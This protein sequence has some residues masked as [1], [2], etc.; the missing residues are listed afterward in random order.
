MH[1]TITAKR[2]PAVFYKNL[3]LSSTKALRSYSLFPLSRGPRKNRDCFS[4]RSTY[5][6]LSRMIRFTL[7]GEIYAVASFL[8]KTDD[9]QDNIG[10][11]YTCKNFFIRSRG[12]KKKTTRPLE[13][14]R[15]ILHN[16][17]LEYIQPRRRHSNW[18]RINLKIYLTAV[19]CIENNLL[20]FPK[21]FRMNFYGWI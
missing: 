3:E 1:R 5:F 12:K 20:F 10:K 7:G 14:R 2:I 4:E 15:K 16:A 13:K 19:Q 17:S 11:R 18:S 8:L 6:I 21:S 9:V